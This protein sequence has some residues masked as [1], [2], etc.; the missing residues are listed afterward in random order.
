MKFD[1][2]IGKSN[3]DDKSDNVNYGAIYDSLKKTNSYLYSIDLARSALMITFALIIYFDF[4]IDEIFK[5]RKEF[6]L[7][8]TFC[9]LEFTFTLIGYK[10]KNQKKV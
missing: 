4:K 3:E 6:G 2:Q 9:I 8:L 10:I 1:E 5:S 7:L